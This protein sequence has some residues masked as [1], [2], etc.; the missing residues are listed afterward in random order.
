MSSAWA[1]MAILVGLPLQAGESPPEPTAGAETLPG[2]VAPAAS[3]E[4]P[5]APAPPDAAPLPLAAPGVD[6]ATPA[7]AADGE[8][9]R[10]FGLRRVAVYDFELSQVSEQIG[11]VV[12]QAV[13][14]ELRKYKGLS[15]IGMSEIQAMLDLESQK[16]IMGCD[17][18]ESCLAEIA[19]ALGVDSIVIGS[20]ALV[21]DG[22]VIAVRRI[23]QHD[24]R[25]A[26]SYT[27][28]LEAEDGAEFLATVGPMIPA[29]FPEHELRP[30]ARVGVDPDVALRLNPP[31]LSPWVFYAGAG[32]AAGLLAGAVVLGAVSATLFFGRYTPLLERGKTAEGAPLADLQTAQDRKSVV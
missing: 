18:D 21:G 24:A 25:V 29:L 27:K 2:A 31:P 14:D 6:A 13:L 10:R 28:R 32:T 26:G 11:H 15:I 8:A 22:H 7:P 20:L 12:T 17:E 19:D 9:T 5:P 4:E 1:V 30:G 3:D 23:D 16:Q